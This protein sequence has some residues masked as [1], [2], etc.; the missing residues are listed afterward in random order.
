MHSKAPTFGFIKTIL[1]ETSKRLSYIDERNKNAAEIC[2]KLN[3]MQPMP[4]HKFYVP[5]TYTRNVP[6]TKVLK[7]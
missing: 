3:H 5:S 2:L 4:C 1:T 6:V 7:K